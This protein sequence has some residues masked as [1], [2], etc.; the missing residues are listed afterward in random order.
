MPTI[1]LITHGLM[2]TILL[3]A[4]TH[5]VV[6]S[7]RMRRSVPRNF[8]EAFANTRAATYTNAVVL[9]YLLT[10]VLGGIIYPVYVLDV[11]GALNDAQ[12]QSAIGAF[13][14]KEHFAILGTAM[15]PTYWYLWKRA[16][17]GALQ[18][19]RAMNT[20]I[21]ALLV[22]TNFL[23]GHVLNNIKGLI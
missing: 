19:T 17:P 12:M 6:S 9:L 10:A 15:L 2:A 20:T 5:Q 11:K 21:I 13:E 16:D 18:V 7:W 3:G 14:L 8:I 1:L 22:W 23:V 4:I